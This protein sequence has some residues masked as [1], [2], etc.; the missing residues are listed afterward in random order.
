MENCTLKT[1][2]LACS[3]WAA[4]MLTN[5]GAAPDSASAQ[6]V[7]WVTRG[8]AVFDLFTNPP[9]AA[10]FTNAEGVAVRRPISKL[11]PTTRK[12][13]AH[14]LSQSLN[15]VV[16]TNFIAHTNG[17]ITRIW[18][19]R[20]HPPGWPAKAPKVNWDTNCLMWGMKGMTALSPCW[21]CEG[22]SGQVPVTA[23]TRRHAYARGHGMGPDGFNT[24]FAGH[25]VW[26]LTTDNLAVART[27]VRDVVRTVS[28]TN[29]QDYTILLLDKDLPESIEPLRVAPLTEVM[30][31]YPNYEYS[32]GAPWPMFLTEQSGHV[33]AMVPG[34]S[35]DVRKGGDSGSPNLLP[36]PGE[37]VFWGG[38]STSSPS[39][40]MQADMDELCRKEGLDPHAYQL[41]WVDLSRY[42]AFDPK[43]LVP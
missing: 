27:V 32:P 34:W 29:E 14:F 4:P 21:S 3:L 18:T 5:A 20:E 38:R 23:L 10:W 15:Q 1:V 2:L 31:K 16:W 35:V 8:A 28:A 11:Y 24:N 42:P 43:N 17:R 30:A 7:G 6:P 40:Q 36:M 26:F 12:E 39:P 13:F 37:L 33:S 25:S 19:V 41:Q 9:P 22:F